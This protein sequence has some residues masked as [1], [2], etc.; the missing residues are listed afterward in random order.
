MHVD[1][2]GYAPKFSILHNANY[3]RKV[4]DNKNAYF[5]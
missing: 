3:I 4:H 5:Q 2:A 1:K